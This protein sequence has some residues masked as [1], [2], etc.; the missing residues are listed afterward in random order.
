MKKKLLKITNSLMSKED[1][2]E[3]KG[4]YGSEG[5]YRLWINNNCGD[6][7]QFTSL[8]QCCATAASYPPSANAKCSIGN[9]YGCGSPMC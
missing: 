3:I 5:Q 9:M 7:Y 4:G 2:K 1:M 8:S 6:G